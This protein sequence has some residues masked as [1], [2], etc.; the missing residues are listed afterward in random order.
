MENTVRPFVSGSNG[1]CV[2]CLFRDRCLT[3]G[4]N[5]SMHALVGDKI[6]L[7]RAV[8]DELQEGRVI[9]VPCCNKVLITGST[10]GLIT[11]SRQK[12]CPLIDQERG[13]SRCI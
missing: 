10:E 8:S 12:A 6:M 9:S 7:T 13:M 11:N 2:F 1:R 4:D 3:C 5:C